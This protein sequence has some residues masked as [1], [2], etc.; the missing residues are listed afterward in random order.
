M[1]FYATF[2]SH[3]ITPTIEPGRI[4]VVGYSDRALAVAGWWTDHIMGNVFGRT[5]EVDLSIEEMLAMQV[6]GVALS[7][8]YI[9]SV[10]LMTPASLERVR[11]EVEQN[12]GIFRSALAGALDADRY[13]SDQMLQGMS[14][15]K[16]KGLRDPYSEEQ[17]ILAN[18]ARYSG[19]PLEAFPLGHGHF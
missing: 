18:I 17:K 11:G 13:E 2:M 1:L 14:T 4:E 5:P 8:P 16:Y 6:E 19:I 9:R 10:S 12:A 15:D 7:S 3:E